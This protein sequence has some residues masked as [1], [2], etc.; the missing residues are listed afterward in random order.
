MA[1]PPTPRQLPEWPEWMDLSTLARYSSSSERTLRDWIRAEINPLPAS[2]RGGKIF[3]NRGDY[4]T[5]MRGQGVKVVD[6]GAIV[7]DICKSLSR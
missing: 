5:W 4:D 1:T 2:R 6:V 7:D 3:V